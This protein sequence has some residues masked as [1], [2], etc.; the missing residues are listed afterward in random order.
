MFL[1]VHC[2]QN[3]FVIQSCTRSP[4]AIVLEKKSAPKNVHVDEFEKYF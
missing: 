3:L 2:F 4:E 1:H